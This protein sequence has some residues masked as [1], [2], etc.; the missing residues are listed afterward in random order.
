MTC[1]ISWLGAVIAL[2][3][4]L[5]AGSARSQ[6]GEGLIWQQTGGATHWG[7]S[8]LSRDPVYPSVNTELADDFNLVGSITRVEVA[9][10]NGHIGAPHFPPPFYGVNVRF[11]APAAD[12]KPGALERQYSLPADDANL[13]IDSQV[14]RSF[15]ITLDPP[16]EATGRHYMV[17]QPVMDPEFQAGWYWGSANDGAPRGNAAWFRDL[18]A[19]NK[20]WHRTFV[21]GDIDSDLSMSLYG[22]RTVQPPSLSQASHTAIPRSG[23]IELTGEGF[24]FNQE[25]SLVRIGGEEALITHWSD[26]TITAYVPESAPLGFEEITV[27]TAG[28]ESN[29]L[30]LEVR[31]RQADGRVRWRFQTDAAAVYSRPVTHTDGTVYVADFRGH[32]FALTP[33]GGLKW[34]FTSP[35]PHSAQ[36]LAIGGD[37]AVFMASYGRLIAVS[38]NGKK[39]W[40]VE[41]P[42]GESIFAGPTLGPDGNLYAVTGDNGKGLGLFSV[43]QNGQRRWSR[44]G[45]RPSPM[46]YWGGEEITFGSGQ[47]YFAAHDGLR[48]YALDGTLRWT[49]P[50]FGQSTVGPDGTIYVKAPPAQGQTGRI[51]AYAPDG[52]LRSAFSEATGSPLAGPDGTVYAIEG[53]HL[54]A[55]ERSGA[56][57]WR[58]SNPERLFEPAVSPENTMLIAPGQTNWGAPC[59]IDGLSI[60]GAGLW[61]LDL[62]VE[63]D[64]PVM[65]AS[66]PRFSRG[67]ETVYL[68]MTGDQYKASDSG[69]LYALDTAPEPGQEL[70]ALV[71]RPERV[72]GGFTAGGV[73][74]L[75]EAAGAGGVVVSLSSDSTIASVPASVTVPRGLR[76]MAF[77]ITTR[78][79]NRVQEAHLTARAGS[80]TGTATL[81]VSP[82]GPVSLELERWDAGG[83]E[84]FSGTVTLNG[85]APDGGVD[86]ALTASSTVVRVP[87]KVTVP[88]G[89]TQGTFTVSVV[90][91][92]SEREV[93]ITASANALQ[94]SAV[95]WV[96]PVWLDDVVLLPN[97][98]VGGDTVSGEVHL[99]GPAP[100]GGLIVYLESSDAG[101][102]TVPQEI[103][104]P[105][106]ARSAEFEAQT[107]SVTEPVTVDCWAYTEEDEIGTWLDLLPSAP[108]DQVVVESAS[109]ATRGATLTLQATTQDAAPTIARRGRKPILT[110][111][112]TKT[113][114]VLGK[115][116][117]L[118]NGKY[119]G[120]IK[121]RVRPERVTVRSSFGG[122]S[123]RVVSSK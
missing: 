3:A 63:D 57:R 46:A 95:L 6:V 2:A 58:F 117:R 25:S 94:A 107:T 123:T 75:P 39:K 12:G 50:G 35:L 90:S 7:P 67:G 120:Q 33:D 38:A 87:A 99:S 103:V 60:A 32:L 1:R 28:G 66:R 84:A 59:Y 83:G 14:P 93:E 122:V 85:P 96:W 70:P 23:R 9:G 81:T 112:D 17:V 24:G 106:G 34:I 104:I 74:T 29:A 22:S 88:A 49:R 110:T 116:R 113:G 73:V 78:A 42:T 92:S 51:A 4:M 98:A 121:T 53:D 56:S 43:T 44:P 79:V 115:L 10:H 119:K 8:Q 55:F 13:V 86:V 72:G 105:E 89:Q 80:V 97:P 45:F 65:P 27:I 47:L 102:L 101:L 16:F 18:N 61:R 15:K 68:G 71:V 41:E 118:P 21:Y 91:T 54:A 5:A 108:A 62:P 19:Q 52:T 109:Y 69:W 40:E 82:P 64:A 77:T 36:A 11:Y 114:K 76:S 37:G 26:T 31:A 100:A 111:Y 48:C 30:P 20:G